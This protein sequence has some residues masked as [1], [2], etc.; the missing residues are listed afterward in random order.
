MTET[1]TVTVSSGASEALYRTLLA[2]NR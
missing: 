2:K 1:V